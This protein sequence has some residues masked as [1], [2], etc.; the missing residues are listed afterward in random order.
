MLLSGLFEAFSSSNETFMLVISQRKCRYSMLIY[1]WPAQVWRIEN[2]ELAPVDPQWYGYFY[3]GDCYLILYTYLVNNKKCYLLYMWQVRSQLKQ[4][5]ITHLNFVCVTV[6]YEITLLCHL[7]FQGRHA[8]QDELAA[9][10]FQA[11]SLD[12][13]YNG[14]PVQ[15]RVTMGREP[16][17]F[18]AIFKGKLVIF[19]VRLFSQ[20]TLISFET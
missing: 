15:V 3:G 18:M 7:K 14:E 10:A 13:K 12:Q 17:H 9:S 5:T 11:V 2:L 20:L 4:F 1:F 16:R 19:E 6:P 8:T